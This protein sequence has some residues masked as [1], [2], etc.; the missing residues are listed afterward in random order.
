MASPRPVPRRPWLLC[1]A[2]L[3]GAGA[4]AL[5]RPGGPEL[6][7]EVRVD[8][9]LSRLEVRVCCAGWRPRRLLLEDEGA[10][11]LLEPLAAATGEASLRPHAEGGLE[12]V[13]LGPG[14]A[15]VAYALDL[16]RLSGGRRTR[17]AQRVGQDLLVRPG[18]VLLR[19]ALWPANLEATVRFDLPPGLEAAVPW[20][21]LDRA[22][23]LYRLDAFALRLDA[24]IALG[25]FAL[26]TSMH[27]GRPVRLALLDQP[28]AFTRAGLE[29]W[30]WAATGAV[31]T[32]YGGLPPPEVLVL[33]R[34]AP[35]RAPP[36]LFGQASRAGGEMVQ[37]LLAAAAPDEA[38]PGEWVLVHELLH[39]CTPWTVAEDA[40]FQEGFVTYYQEVLRARAGLISAGA[41]WANLLDGFRR[42]AGAGTGRVLG[43]ESRLM[44]R[45]HAYWRVYWSG[46]ALALAIDAQWRKQSGG[47]VGL[48]DAMRLWN[49]RHGRLTRPHRALDL[50]AEA[51]REL[52]VTGGTQAAA[53]ALA[54]DAFPDPGPVLA[55]LGV[56]PSGPHRASLVPAP[57]A[58]VRD[59]IMR[60][61]GGSGNRYEQD[62]NR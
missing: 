21:C 3:L 18:L 14:R 22:R 48:D 35:A 62:A 32:L 43:E 38:L 37:A 4:P 12:P 54:A 60:A 9:A 52:G 50:L 39:L 28:C 61:P 30:V 26:W 55:W 58:A 7:Y 49:R 57:G 25:R 15:C 41:A 42:G 6:A 8:P 2:A 46:A 45:T 10:L 19:P 27:H 44:A 11:A 17:E 23:R 33:V 36:V 40:W 13:G 1:L 31:A 59:A 20:P 5:A 47:R 53:A 24:R 51:E 29:R 34:P 56:V 16:E